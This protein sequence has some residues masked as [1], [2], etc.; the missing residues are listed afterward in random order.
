ML[1]SSPLVGLRAV[2]AVLLNV[3]SKKAD[4]RTIN[5]LKCKKSFRPVRERL[6][7]LSAVHKPGDKTVSEQNEK[8]NSKR[9]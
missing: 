7:H 2:R 6:R 1:K 5:V 3:H 8:N 9:R 4:L